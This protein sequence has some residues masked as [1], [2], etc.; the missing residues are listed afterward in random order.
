MGALFARFGVYL[1]G[2]FSAYFPRMVAKVL[3]FFGVKYAVRTF[4]MQQFI[5][6][7]QGALA[8]APRVAVDA[9]ASVRFDQAVTIILSAYITAAAIRLVV[10]QASAP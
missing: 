8:G 5:A 4:A 7:I 3:V 6:Y 10:Q 2:I 1:V 9:L